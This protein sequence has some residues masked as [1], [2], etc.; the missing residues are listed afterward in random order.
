M[1]PVAAYVLVGRQHRKMRVVSKRLR[2][3][4]QACFMV[5]L[6]TNQV[7]YSKLIF[8]LLFTLPNLITAYTSCR[9]RKR[10][11]YN[12][13]LF[14]Q[15]WE[16]NLIKLHKQ[17]IDR[18]YRPGRS[19]C[20]VVTNPKP[21]EIFAADF[22][23]RVVHHLLVNKIEPFFEKRFIF[24]SYACR[25]GKGCHTAVD[26]LHLAMK[27]ASANFSRPVYFVQL[28]VRQFFPSIDKAILV[29]ILQRTLA[30]I[31]Q[32]K[33]MLLKILWL[34]EVIVW[35]DPT[36][37]YFFKGNQKKIQQIPKTKS[38][39]TVPSG[40][41]LPIGNLT[42]QFFANI[43]LNELDQYVK[44]TLKVPYYLRYA[45]DMVLLAES[46]D[47]LK[48]WREKIDV[49]LQTRL[50]LQLHPLKD[51]YGSVYQGI[52]FVGYMVKPKYR[53][54]RQRVVR[55]LKNKLFQFNRQ[56]LFAPA[57]ISNQLSLPL[58]RKPSQA[59]IDHMMSVVNSYYGHLLHANTYRLR[60]HLY[61]EHFGELKSFLK[62]NKTVTSFLP[63][64]ATH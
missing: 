11:T 48:Q 15:N 63:I 47:Q 46:I 14:E 10:N 57:E 7:Q 23:D 40:K 9:H 52:D 34:I 6:F 24:D 29:N 62:P 22:R 4:I 12:A 53:L 19:I 36:T 1:V 16:A 37:N 17:L 33:A 31:P 45:D 39:F 44:R 38:L 41:G 2:L 42:S 21:R 27:R 5:L 56:L 51:H 58:V 49:F 3:A 35:H 59:E 13:L 18:T 20:F 26:R 30:D 43:Y 50:E 60:K 28:D 54:S 25:E 55:A 8:Q 32:L 61:E 64:S